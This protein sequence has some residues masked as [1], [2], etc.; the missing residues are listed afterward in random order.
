MCEQ[1]LDLFPS[2]AGDLKLRC[3]GKRPRHVTGIFVGRCEGSSEPPYSDSSA[4]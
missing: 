4:P 3:C 1:H 2:A